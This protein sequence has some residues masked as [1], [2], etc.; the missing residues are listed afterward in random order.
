MMSMVIQPMY[1]S[2]AIFF[3]K[4]ELDIDEI[5]VEISLL[6][7]LILQYK[8]ESRLMMGFGSSDPPFPFFSYEFLLE[9]DSKI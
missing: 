4:T 3:Q 6:L 9:F 2:I 5:I 1:T 7:A 8:Q